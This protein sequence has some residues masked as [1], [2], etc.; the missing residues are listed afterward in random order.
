MQ[1]VMTARQLAD[2]LQL[3]EM[4][5]YKRVRLGEIPAVKMGRVLR[6]KKN[7][8]DKWLEI[9]SGWDQEFETL[10]GRS[11]RFGKEVG[12]TEQKIQQAI[13]EVR[14]DRG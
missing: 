4:T 8:I 1:E 13:E 3:N 7:V 11:Q 10:L 6:F 2:Y 12:I 14:K 5:I 9:E